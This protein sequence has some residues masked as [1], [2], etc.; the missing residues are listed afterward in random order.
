MHLPADSDDDFGPA[1]SR[2]ILPARP[3]SDDRPVSCWGRSGPP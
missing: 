1:S 2:L 3:G